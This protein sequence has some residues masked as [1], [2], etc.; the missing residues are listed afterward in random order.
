MADDVIIDHSTTLSQAKYLLRKIAYRR[1]NRHGEWQSKEQEVYDRGNAATVLLY[2]PDSGKVLLT[3]QFRIPTFVNGNPSGMLIEACAGMLEDE[4]PEMCI[5]RETEEEM[6]YR[7]EVFK[8]LFNL[9]MSAGALTEKLYFFAAKYTEGDKVSNGGG[10][11][12]EKEDITV[13]EV[14]FS[15]ALKMVSNGEIQDAKTVILL[16]YAEVHGL[17]GNLATSTPS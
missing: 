16:Q 10:L 12:A 5:R 1:I 9:Y 11:E 3:R 8:P 14:P 4:T 15:D 2:N 13:L 17:M 6:G 7:L